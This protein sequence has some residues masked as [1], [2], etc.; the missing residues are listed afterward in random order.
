MRKAFTGILLFIS[1]YGLLISFV[2]DFDQ[3]KTF[4]SLWNPDKYFVSDTLI[5]DRIEDSD[6]EMSSPNTFYYGQLQKY[7]TK[8][9]VLSKNGG[10]IDS[11][12]PVWYCVISEQIFDNL[13]NKLGGP[14]SF[15]FINIIFN[16]FIGFIWLPN[17]LYFIYLK[18]SRVKLRATLLALI[19]AYF[20]FFLYE[21]V[22]DFIIIKSIYSYIQS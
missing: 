21:I 7:K 13:D 20:V 11:K 1:S 22:T 6:S 12:V 18:S 10:F 17:L 2:Y 5:Y 16:T 8:G 9:R 3:V 19:G 15:R 4:Y 14:I